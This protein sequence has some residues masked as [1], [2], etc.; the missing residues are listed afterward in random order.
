MPQLDSRCP[1]G[2]ARHD[3]RS[4]PASLPKAAMST[5]G[6]PQRSSAPSNLEVFLALFFFFALAFIALYLTPH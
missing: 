3:R 2:L 1:T 6:V 5:L 4:S